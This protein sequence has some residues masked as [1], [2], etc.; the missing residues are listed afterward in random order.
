MSNIEPQASK[1]VDP[2]NPPHEIPAEWL[3][4]ICGTRHR[5]EISYASYSAKDE[6]SL[7]VMIARC[8]HCATEIR[9]RFFVSEG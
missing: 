9:A 4:P 8:D 2:R 5:S 1:N 7:W 6:T 3:C